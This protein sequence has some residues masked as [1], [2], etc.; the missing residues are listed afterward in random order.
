MVLL[1][2]NYDSFTYNLYDYI[3]QL[4]FNCLVIR[5]D[6]LS[7]SDI[8][9][10]DF[11]SIVFSPGPCTPSESGV[12]MEV[13]Q[14]YYQSK[15]I[16]GICLGHQA[17]GQFFNAQLKKALKPIHGKTSMIQL[18]E[19]PIFKDLSS[20]IE[21]MR[22]HSLVLHVVKSPL[23]VISTT[24]SNEVMAIAHETLPI[25]GVQ[26]HP[27]SIL[28]QDGLQILKNWFNWIK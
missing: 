10:L 5:N 26:F 6:E 22:Y 7:L 13:I 11:N 23:K 4:G 2:D 20:E 21:V 15:P 16:L 28:T 12:C 24:S 9:K 25:A 18:D 17:L 8:I 14:H 27:E 19:H 3:N 1:I